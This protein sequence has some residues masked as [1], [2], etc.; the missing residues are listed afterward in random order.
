VSVLLVTHDWGV[1]ADSC[2]RAVVMYAGQIVECAE[3]L[4]M[5]RRPMHPY[6][7]ALLAS[8]PHHAPET[9]KLPTIPGKVP[10]PGDWPSGCHF[11]P[12]CAY[13]TAAC[14]E[15]PIV[16]VRLPPGRETRC[17]HREESFRAR[18]KSPAGHERRETVCVYRATRKWALSVRSQ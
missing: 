1:V 5:F 2:D 14:R 8:N 10:S 17:I 6:T 11:H 4:S 3:L 13:A 15:H 9:E 16:L 18:C 7:Q 12:R